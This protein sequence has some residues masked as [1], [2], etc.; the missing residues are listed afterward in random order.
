VPSYSC[1]PDDTR[2][3]LALI[4]AGAFPPERFID[5]YYPLSQTAAAFTDMARGA[6]VVKAVLTFEERET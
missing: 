4:A 6:E 2:A 5:R 1:G 3:A